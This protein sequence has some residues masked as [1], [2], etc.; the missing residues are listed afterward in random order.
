MGGSNQ[1]F[2]AYTTDGETYKVSPQLGST[3]VNMSEESRTPV[4]T[5]LDAFG[6]QTV[7]WSDGGGNL[8]YSFRVRGGRYLG[9][10]NLFDSPVGFGPLLQATYD[11]LFVDGYIS[12]GA[13]TPNL[14]SSWTI[15]LSPDDLSIVSS[16]VN[17]FPTLKNL[18]NVLTWTAGTILPNDIDATIT[19]Y[20][21]FRN[22]KVIGAV[23][24]NA[25]P[26]FVY[27]FVDCAAPSRNP[28][29]YSVA[30]VGSDGMSAPLGVKRTY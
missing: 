20:L 11:G 8:L 7:L 9:P 24:A 29:I 19:G 26:A 18:E 13:N 28:A 10:Y 12:S 21:I 23:A 2:A 17:I 16:T 30:A 3:G 14:V 25:D 4:A 15:L 27:R 1:P 5:A 22:G 6:N